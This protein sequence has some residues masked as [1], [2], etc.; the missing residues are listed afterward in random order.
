MRTY[1]FIQYC[2][3]EVEI[4][5]HLARVKKVFSGNAAASGIQATCVMWD[6]NLL[7]LEANPKIAKQIKEGAYVLVDYRPVTGLSVF[8]PRQTIM[9]VLDSKDGASLWSMY[10]EEFDRLKRANKP[11]SAP[12]QAQ[13]M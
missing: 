6:E 10:R 1:P 4:M 9:R 8:H 3:K 13:Y 11:A 7:T 2:I 5:F 12:A